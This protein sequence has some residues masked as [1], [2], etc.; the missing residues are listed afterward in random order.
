MEEDV[1][2]GGCGWRKEDVDAREARSYTY[3]L[4]DIVSCM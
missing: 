3:F 4:A 1:D 2:G